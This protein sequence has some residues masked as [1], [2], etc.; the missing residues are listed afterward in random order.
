MLPIYRLISRPARKRLG[1]L[2]SL[3]FLHPIIAAPE[4]GGQPEKGVDGDAAG[5]A[6]LRPLF[7]KV[8]LLIENLDAIAVPVGVIDRAPRS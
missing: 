1:I 2:I 6:E 4:S 7:D 5:P 3:I 8:S